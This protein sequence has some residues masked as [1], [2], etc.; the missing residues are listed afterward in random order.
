[1]VELGL[2][3]KSICCQSLYSLLQHSAAFLS[4]QCCHR[5]GQELRPLLQGWNQ[6]T[7]GKKRMEKELGHRL[8]SF[9]SVQW[10]FV[11]HY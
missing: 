6:D 7:E 10:T 8:A 3:A 4:A 5:L 11:A 9:S 1:M 2:E